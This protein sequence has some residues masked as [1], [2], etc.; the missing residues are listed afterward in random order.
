MDGCR[1]TLTLLGV[2]LPV[3]FININ[4]WFCTKP[5][6]LTQTYDVN[7]AQ[8]HVD[9]FSTSQSHTRYLLN[10]VTYVFLG[11]ANFVSSVA[12]LQRL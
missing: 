3:N 5:S 2:V 11:W 9:V 4:D 1:L 6:S 12:R 10:G 7:T 8:R